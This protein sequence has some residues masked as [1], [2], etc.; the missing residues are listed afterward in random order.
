[1]RKVLLINPHELKQG[2]FFC[3]PLGLL[4]IAGTLRDKGI[5]VQF[6]DGCIRGLPGIREKIRTY[7]PDIVG[8][9]THTSTR[10]KAL[11]IARMVKDINKNATVVMGG[12]HP[13][14]MYQQLLEHYDDVDIVVRGEG[15]ISFLKIA[16]GINLDKI[17]GIVYRDGTKVIKNS[18]RRYVENLDTLPFPAWDLIADTLQKYPTTFPEGLKNYDGID[19]SHGPRIPVMYSRGCLGHCDFCSSWWIWKKPRYRS[20]KN[21]VDEIE[22]LYESFK[23][24]HFCFY[25]DTLTMNKQATIDLCDEIVKRRLHIAF[26]VTTRVDCVDFEI[27]EKLKQAGCYAVGYGIETASPRLLSKMKKEYDVQTSEKAIALTRRAGLIPGVLLIVGYIGE[28]EETIDETI[29]FLQRTG[30]ES[31]GTVGGLWLFPGTGTYRYAKK[32]GV[33]DDNF[34]LGDKSHM[35]YTREH[36]LRKL[37]FFIYAIR[38]RKKISEMTFGYHVGYVLRT[39]VGGFEQKVLSVLNRSPAIERMLESFYPAI[40]RSISRI[41][42]FWEGRS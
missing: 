26:Y 17:D 5:D 34:W 41:I 20:A 42:H 31:V 8:I 15:E 19:I 30:V 28:T 14:I 22:W 37:R 27:L 16:Q 36:S 7:F 35:I 39:Y 11:A 6:I 23:I 4:Y 2:D 18:N 3:P 1:M 12:V 38:D 25:D 29:D 32:I 21:M 10:K 9:T 13:T 33:I 40:R 24:Q